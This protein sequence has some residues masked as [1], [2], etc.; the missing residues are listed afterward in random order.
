MLTKACGVHI[1]FFLR[2]STCWSHIMLKLHT[3]RTY[4]VIIYLEKGWLSGESTLRI[5]AYMLMPYVGW[6][7]CWFSPL[8]RE[9][10]LQ[11]RVLWFSSPLPKNKFLRT[12]KCS[13]GK[14]ITYYY[15]SNNNYIKVC[16]LIIRRYYESDAVKEFLSYLSFS[17]CTFPPPRR[18]DRNET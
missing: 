10:F 5:P 12:P 7:C 1:R 3:M 6:V 14:Q 15:T 18:Q 9:V 11:E 13:M 4:T 2:G 16:G 17:F 8:L